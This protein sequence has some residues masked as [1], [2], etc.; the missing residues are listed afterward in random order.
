MIS[1]GL[2]TGDGS[3]GPGALVTWTFPEGVEA[4]GEIQS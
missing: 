4:T 1:E 2:Q 3:W